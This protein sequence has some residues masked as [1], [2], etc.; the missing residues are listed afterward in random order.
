MQYDSSQEALYHPESRPVFAWVDRMPRFD[1]ASPGLSLANVWWLAN[2]SHLAYYDAGRVALELDRVGLQLRACFSTECVQAY[3]AADDAFA[4]LAFR[5]TQCDE[6]AD[7]KADVDIRLAAFQGRAEV[8]R[9][10]LAALDEAWQAIDETLQAAAAQGLSTWYTGHSLGAALATLA[11]AR[12]SPAGLVT[13]ASPR[14]GNAEFAKLLEG[15]TVQRVVNC[16]D[17][18]VTLPT[19]SM[20][21]QHVGALHFITSGGRLLICPSAS[22]LLWSKAVGICRYWITFPWFRQGFLVARS[23]ADHSITNYTA[24]LAQAAARR[25]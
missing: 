9:G 19:Q 13:F 23:L 1:P 25:A 2:A 4:I 7:L 21:Y 12:R 20:G 22:H 16:A 11:A 14:V 5:G 3:V 6:F 24:A 17:V 15:V 10:F 18:V 8:H